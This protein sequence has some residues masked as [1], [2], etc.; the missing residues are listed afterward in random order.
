VEISMQQLLEKEEM[1]SE[2]GGA[3]TINFALPKEQEAM[4]FSEPP[5]H[6]PVIS[7]G[8]KQEPAKPKKDKSKATLA[9]FD[10]YEPVLQSAVVEFEPK[11]A[12]FLT[13]TLIDFELKEGANA[14]VDLKHTKLTLEG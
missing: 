3:M 14:K 13:Q 7:M 11:H 6:E 9:F 8:V 2:G 5:A 4:D 1:E 12:L 10:F